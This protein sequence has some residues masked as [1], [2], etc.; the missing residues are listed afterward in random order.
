VGWLYYYARRYDQARYHLTRAIAMNPTA[1]EN[2]RVVGLALSQQDLLREAEQVL[3][4]AL[5]LPDAGTY[6]KATLGYVLARAGKRRAAV[7]LL[8][9]LEAIARHDYVSPAAFITLHLDLGDHQRALDWA[10]RAYEERRGWMA[11]LAVHPIVDSLRAE[12]RFQAL[13]TRMRL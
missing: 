11:Y 13:V 8:D 2:Y 3:R 4:E 5:A 1:E 6:S 10:D 9:E 12:P 7:A